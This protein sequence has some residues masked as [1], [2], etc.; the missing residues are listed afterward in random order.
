M[1]KLFAEFAPVSAGAWRAQ[2]EKDLKGEPYDSLIWKNENG[3]DV[4]PFY[5]A[6]DLKTKYE[7]AFTHADWEI[8]V[9]AS[10]SAQEVNKKL[11][12]ALDSGASAIA[13]SLENTDLTGMLKDVQL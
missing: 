11:I 12:S 8:C 5:T 10:G 3:F 9:K 13:V 6:E 1:K 7:P 2:L 4:Q